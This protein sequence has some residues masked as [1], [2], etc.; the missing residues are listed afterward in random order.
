MV[1]NDAEVNDSV[2][3]DVGMVDPAREIAPR[4]FGR[5]VS[6]ESDVHKEGPSCVGAV[7]GT[8]EYGSPM[9]Q[10]SAA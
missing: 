5:V 9:E 4:R 10:I 3:V 6:R 7:R 1:F 8:G 2:G